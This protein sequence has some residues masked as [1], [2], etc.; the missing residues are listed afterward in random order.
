[1]RI[2]IV[3]GFLGCGKT[4]LILALAREMVRKGEKVAII[5]NDFGRVN[6]D[7]Q[8]MENAGLQVREL[9]MGCICCTLGPDFLMNLK[10]LAIRYSP[11]TIIV[12]P[13]GIANSDAILGSLE[14]YS[15][16]PF[17]DVKVVY[18]IDGPRFSSMLPAFE[19][20]LINN[21]KMANFVCINKFDETGKQDADI[22]KDWLGKRKLTKPVVHLSLRTNVGLDLVMEKVGL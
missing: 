19:V 12:E 7:S 2:I 17:E 15:G 22:I 16:P 8:I 5:E 1:M 18:I 9:S 10:E 11:D 20:G 4:T 13:S 3:S 21:L 6:I 14:H